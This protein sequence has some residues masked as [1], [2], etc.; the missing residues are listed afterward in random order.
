M[1]ADDQLRWHGG[2]QP[3]RL[4][5]AAVYVH[6]AAPDSL[7][8]ARQAIEAYATRLKLRL[9][10]FYSDNYERAVLAGERLSLDQLLTGARHGA[11]EVVVTPST[12]L[13]G[14]TS[15][16]IEK[17]LNVLVN[18]GIDVQVIPPAPAPLTEET[19]RHEQ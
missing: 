13:F 18:A 2:D 17:V 15:E 12:E 19:G 10:A 6:T 14:R 16:D 9:V 1:N 11:F 4:R 3:I 8:A 5:K 7:T